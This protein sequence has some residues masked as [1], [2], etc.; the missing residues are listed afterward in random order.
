MSVVERPGG[1]PETR[2]EGDRGG[3]ALEGCTDPGRG[4]GLTTTAT[5]PERAVSVRESPASPETK[6]WRRRFYDRRVCPVCG[7]WFTATASN[8]RF[9]PPTDRDR[10]R[11]EH[12]QPRSRCAKR[13]DNAKQPGWDPASRPCSSP[14]SAPSA[15]SVACLGRTCLPTRPGS[16][17]AATSRYGTAPRNG[18][19]GD[20]PTRA[21]YKPSHAPMAWRPCLRTTCRAAWTRRCRPRPRASSLGDSCLLSRRS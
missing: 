14:S 1:D 21:A 11:A 18:R 7:R 6:P 19:R 20:A 3:E 13:A 10:D 12:S 5:G 17:A 4:I 8:Q 2:R 15:G 9:C 16:V